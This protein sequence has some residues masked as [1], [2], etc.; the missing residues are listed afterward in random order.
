MR[1][2]IVS[3]IGLLLLLS[4]PAGAFTL[5]FPELDLTSKPS[6][7][8][9][10]T[11]KKQF[12]KIAATFPYNEAYERVVHPSLKQ[13]HRISFTADNTVMEILSIDQINVLPT[14]AAMR[15]QII[16][17]FGQPDTDEI[18]PDKS[19]RITYLLPHSENARRVFLASP[20]RLT[21]SLVTDRFLAQ[22]EG[23]V[24]QAESSAK[25][26]KQQQQMITVK[27]WLLP[28]AWIVG[29][30]A[31]GFVLVRILPRPLREPV[32]GFFSKVFGEIYAVVRDTFAWF[33]SMTFGLLLFGLWITSGLAVGAGALEM[34][35]SWWWGVAWICGSAMVF[36]GQDENTMKSWYLAVFFFTIALLGPF[37]QAWLIGGGKI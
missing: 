3:V 1:Y 32:S 16:K 7:I 30:G 18:M 6:E 19:L 24:E 17:N 12:Q 25:K 35:T 2:I 34:Q 33:F 9:A 36:R 15:A 14:T 31:G 11:Q 29:L 21:M 5:V 37:A 20:N 13:V 26:D 8:R 10:W 23:Q 28:L 4:S 22:L 27:T